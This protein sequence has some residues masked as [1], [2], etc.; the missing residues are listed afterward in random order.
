MDKN[1]E[2]LDKLNKLNETFSSLIKE[3]SNLVDKNKE[4]KGATPTAQDEMMNKMYN[5]MGSI[6]NNLHDRIDFVHKRMCGLEDEHYKHKSTQNGHL[7]PIIGA[8]KMNKA[9][10]ALGLDNEYNVNKKELY[11]SIKKNY[12][13]P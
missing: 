7:P 13:L 6:A 1:Q 12:T 5:M 9:L 10:K 3:F 4:I 11:A 2:N 8:G